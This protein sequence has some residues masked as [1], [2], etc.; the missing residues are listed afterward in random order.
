LFY[1]YE[2]VCYRSVRASVERAPL[3]QSQPSRYSRVLTQT[4]TRL[5]ITNLSLF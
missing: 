4:T 3:G 2:E 5:A 1:R